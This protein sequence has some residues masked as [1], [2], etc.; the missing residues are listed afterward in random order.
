M[1][2][3]NVNIFSFVLEDDIDDLNLIKELLQLHGITNYKLFQNENDLYKH[4]TGDISV[5]ILDHY[6][7]GGATGLDVCRKIKEKS[8]DSY[9]IVMTGQYDRK[10]VIDYLNIGADK[11][12]DKNDDDRFAKLRMYLNE[13]LAY[14]S[15]RLEEI[16]I[17]QRI[18]KSRVSVNENY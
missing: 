12:I 17:L 5:C 6:L 11:Y 3:G 1:K 10:V 2:V 18:S 8:V 9:I 14:A 13:A 15:R 4:L 7:M 16:S